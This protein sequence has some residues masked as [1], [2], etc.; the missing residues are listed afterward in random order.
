MHLLLLPSTEDLSAVRQQPAVLG[1][2]VVWPAEGLV[3]EAHTGS[4]GVVESKMSGYS[5]LKPKL[6]HS[7]Q[8][9]TV[10]MSRLELAVAVS[11]AASWCPGF[12]QDV[13]H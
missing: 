12:E 2:R 1:F 4:V 8:F 9:D 3:L 10:V 7:Q 5:V 13:D 6:G 11:V